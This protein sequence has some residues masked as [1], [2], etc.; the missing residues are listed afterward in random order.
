MALP[1]LQLPR[2]GHAATADGFPVRL[3]IFYQPNGTKRELWRP[4]AGATETNFQ[5]GPLMAPLSGHINDL[6]IM[7][8]L[9][10]TAARHGPGG[11][12]QRGMASVLT[13]AVITEGSL[14]REV[15]G[16]TMDH[17]LWTDSRRRTRRRVG[18]MALLYFTRSMPAPGANNR[19][20]NLFEL[21]GTKRIL[22]G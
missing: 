4:P 6:V 3:I 19:D 8:G 1:L 2:L 13:G 7:D 15:E 21:F 10:L 22:F 20:T 9:D 12:H 16:L 18:L 11:P 14:T 17:A 5:L